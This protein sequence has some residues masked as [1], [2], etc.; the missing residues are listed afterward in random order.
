M[1]L[2][3]NDTIKVEY[4]NEKGPLFFY[5]VL[6]LLLTRFSEKIHDFL[7]KFK[8]TEKD[9][10]RGFADIDIGDH[11]DPA[12]AETAL[13]KYMKQLVRVKSTRLTRFERF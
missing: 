9:L 2:S 1:S 5:P 11:N 8:D 4:S 6:W 12:T 13:T 3:I 7:T 10:T